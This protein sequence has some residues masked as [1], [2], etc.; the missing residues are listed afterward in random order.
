MRSKRAKGKSN[1]DAE[2][3]MDTGEKDLGFEPKTDIQNLNNNEAA[4]VPEKKEA[5]R[6]RDIKGLVHFHSWE[7]SS[8]AKDSLVRIKKAV[9]KKTG[10]EYIGMSEHIGFPGEE[11]WFDKIKREFSDIDRINEE[12]EGP[13]IFKGVEVNVFSDGTVDAPDDILD[14]AEIVVA[15][16]HYKNTDS[17]DSLGEVAESTAP[18][19][20]NAMEKYLDINFLGHPLR[21]VPVEDWSKVDF[22]AICKSAKEHNVV[23]EIGIAKSAP[24]DLPE[25]F[26]NAVKKYGNLISICPDFHSIGDYLEESAEL[27]DEEKE[28]LAQYSNIKS[29]IGSINFSEDGNIKNY[30]LWVPPHSPEKIEKKKIDLKMNRERLKEIEEGDALKSIYEALMASEQEAVQVKNS[31]SQVESRI[32][33]KK[34]H[35]SYGMLLYYGR[36]IDKIKKSLDGVNTQNI[37][38]LWPEKKFSAW[39]NDRKKSVRLKRNIENGKN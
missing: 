15:S 20:I 28:L 9:N 27:S 38:S 7:G 12:G 33:D 10:L 35:M 6:F 11:Y 22:D 2:D 8:C 5:W 32:V 3:R 39:I 24:G 36:K 17:P 37:I 30:G 16:N 31:S 29:T 23:I 1:F 13:K 4:E 19:W 18:R 14:Q 26:Y 21:D 25:S 34:R